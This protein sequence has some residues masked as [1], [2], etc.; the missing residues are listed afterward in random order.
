[1][2]LGPFGELEEDEPEML[3]PEEVRLWQARGELAAVARQTIAD[4]RPRLHTV[5]EFRIYAD[6]VLAPPRLII[7]GAGHVAYHLAQAAIA[8]G[9]QVTVV[10]DRAE[11]ALP[12]RPLICL[13]N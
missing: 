9:F 12:E 11:Y 4:G 13:L 1:M 7:A 8:A 5:G 2:V 6:P 10:D 3:T